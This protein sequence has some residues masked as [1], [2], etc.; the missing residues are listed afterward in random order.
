MKAQAALLH[1]LVR[2]ARHTHFGRT[3][4]FDRITDVGSYQRRIPV[5]P[6]SEFWSDWWQPHYPD[7]FGQTWPGRI[8]YFAMTSGTTTG[9][10][11]H[12]PYTED[13][14]TAARRG[15]IDL[16]CHHL[17]HR[18]QSRV[19]GGG[20]LGLVGPVDLDQAANGVGTGA[21]S[22]ITAGSVP[23]W[24]GDRLLPPPEIAALTD[25]QEKVRKLAPLSLRSDLRF[26]GGSPNWMLIFLDE[27][28]RASGTPEGR[29]KDWYPNLELI[30]HGGVNF[31]PYRQ[32]FADL[33]RGGH[34]ETREIYSAS[35]GVFAY[36]DRG[37]GGGMRLHLDGQVFFEFV[38]KDQIGTKSPERFWLGNAQTGVDYALVVTT[39]AGL[40]SYVVGDVVRLVDLAPPRLLVVGRVGND[41]SVFGEH[42]IEAE[43]AGAL[44]AAAEEN[45]LSIRDYC[46]GPVRNGRRNHHHYLVETTGVRP[47]G[48]S[49]ALAQ[50]IDRNLQARNEDYAELRKNDLALSPPEV[51]FVPPNGFVNWM[52][53]RRGLGGQFKVPRIINDLDLLSDIRA[54]A[55]HPRPEEHA[56]N[57]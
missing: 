8:P 20:A 48:S 5:R 50:S 38:P 41:L 3:H 40:W 11:K 16:L 45:G 26:M 44:S 52:K 7:L 53:K 19:L 54:V 24:L 2:R 21:V 35:E 14:R 36:A 51:E 33:M 27:V 17:L 28:A 10:S 55:L 57:A 37:D 43:L 9:R 15:F 31:A 47:P 34:A 32:R 18:P 25:W 56:N 39:A 23:R 29:L 6:Y 46:V 4:G 22:A 13:M 30:V 12:I 1:K 42:L 49:R